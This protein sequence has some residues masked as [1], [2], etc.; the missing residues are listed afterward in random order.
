MHLLSRCCD[1]NSAPTFNVLPPM[2]TDWQLPPAACNSAA[3]LPAQA[4]ARASISCWS[5]STA[6]ASSAAPV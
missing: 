6:C 1:S 4:V 5:G 3:A 2:N